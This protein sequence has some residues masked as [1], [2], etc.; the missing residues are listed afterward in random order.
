TN[1]TEL[2]RLLAA[3]ETDPAGRPELQRQMTEL[4]TDALRAGES[5]RRVSI[6]DAG[7][8][9]IASTRA[10]D[11]GLRLSE[12]PYWLE[13]RLRNRVSEL[14]RDENGPVPFRLV[15]PVFSGGDR[16]GTAVIETDATTLFV[17]ARD[18]RGLGRTGETVIVR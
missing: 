17:V 7:G 10:G 3:Y 15:G 1:R 5:F 18:Y 12:Q 9:V 8:T 2:R 4:V 11:V 16:V 14:R 13:G 6:T